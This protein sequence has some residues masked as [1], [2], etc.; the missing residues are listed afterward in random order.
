MKTKIVLFLTFFT[1]SVCAQFT[2]PLG[3]GN[4]GIAFNH[5]FDNYILIDTNQVWHIAKPEKD[6]LF[7]NETD[8]LLFGNSAIITDTN[9]YYSRNINS[10]FQ[11]ALS[12]TL[13]F[14]F[15]L[16]IFHKYDFQ[17]NRDGGIIEVSYDEGLNWKNIINDIAVVDSNQKG[18]LTGLYTTTDTVYS[19]KNQPAFTGTQS[20]MSEITIPFKLSNLNQGIGIVI[21]RFRIATDSIDSNNEG[22]IISAV[23]VDGWLQDAIKEI[24]SNP[25]IDIFIDSSNKLNASIKNMEIKQLDIISIDGKLVHHNS[26]SNSINVSDLQKGIYILRINNLYSKKILK[27]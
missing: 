23:N 13:P 16:H 24:D 21:I 5:E 8:S 10:Y 20:D 4:N 11:I 15:G 14:E 22:W 26:N 18:R 27:N 19:F 17:K 3:A 25:D 1:A 7:L 12:W 6:I 2:I 9:K